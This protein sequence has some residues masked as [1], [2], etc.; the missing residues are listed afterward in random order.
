MS[1]TLPA[2]L[3]GVPW[4]IAVTSVSFVVGAVAG[5]PICA[6]RVS[7][8]VI[9]RSVAN[10][11]IVACRSIPP[12]VLLFFIFFGVGNGLL[13]MSGFT[14]AVIGLGLITAANMSEIYRG[15]LAAI[16]PG[17]FEASRALN[18][19]KAQQFRD[20]ILPQLGRIALPS[21]GTYLI[22]LLKDSAI[23]STIGV[24]ELAF[25]AYHLSQETFRGLS[26]YAET[27]LLYILLSLP[28]AYLARRADAH[29]RSKVSR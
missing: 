1:L 3:S 18:L 20:V 9:A 19:S 23:A 8:N 27:A 25:Q 6:M 14:A 11:F 28:V 17:Q 12:I 13:A 29:M 21:A 26:I 7:K 2:L 10:V 16:H 5:L 4:T 24:G 22:G 15:S